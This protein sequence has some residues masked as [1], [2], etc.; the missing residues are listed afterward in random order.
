MNSNNFTDMIQQGFRIAVG[1][2][3]TAVET[4]Q[5]KEKINQKINELN[6]ELQEK[7]QVWA[8][9][10]AITE[11]EAKRIIEQFFNKQQTSN[12]FSSEN[13]SSQSTTTTQDIRNLT[14]EIISLRN[15]LNQI[16]NKSSD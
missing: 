1:A 16:N 5:D 10:G 3:A 15:E 9:K 11:E 6:K 4:L 2:T 13:V 7:S 12:D 8:Q 14:A